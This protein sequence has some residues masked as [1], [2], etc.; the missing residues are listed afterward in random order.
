L[1][2]GGGGEFVGRPARYKCPI[3]NIKSELTTKSQIY[4]Y[5]PEPLLL[6]LLMIVVRAFFLLIFLILKSLVLL[7]GHLKN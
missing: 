5:L 2:V 7:I 4:E 1:E 3:E 6:Q